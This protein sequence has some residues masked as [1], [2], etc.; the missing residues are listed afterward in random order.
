MNDC[1]MFHV[2]TMKRYDF[3]E[4]KKKYYTFEKLCVFA[5]LNLFG[6]YST[7]L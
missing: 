3:A 2:R 6:C 1:N 4:N 7:L 5:C